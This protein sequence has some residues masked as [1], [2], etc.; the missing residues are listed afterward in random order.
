MKR[1]VL[2]S[3]AAPSELFIGER[4]GLSPSYCS[5]ST[6]EEEQSLV[7]LAAIDVGSN[8]MRL[9]IASVDDDGRMHVVHTDREPVRLG[10]DVFSKGTISDARLVEA[11]DAFLKFRKL[12]NAYKVKSVRAVGTSALREARN[13]NYCIRQIA[14]TTEIT[15][16]VISAEEEARL[17]FLAASGAFKL[18]RKIAL[19]V[20]IGGGSVE[21]SLAAKNEIISTESFGIGTVRLLEMIDQRTQGERVFR[22]LA[23]GYI[24]VSGTR[25][26]KALGEQKIDI[27]IGT[28]GNVESLGDLRVQLCDADDNR[29]I[30]LDELDIILTQLQSRSYEERIKEFGLRRDRADVIIPAII[31]L[32]TVAREARV[33]EI[34]IPRV[35]LREGLLI[36]MARDLGRR[37]PPP[38]RTQLVTSARLLGRKYDYEPEHAQTVSR[39]AVELFDATKRLHRLGSDERVLLEVAGLLHDVGYYLGTTN[40]HK[41]TWYLINA[42][43]LVGCSESEKAIIALVTRYH[44]RSPPKSSHK[45]FVDVPPKRRRLVLM[46][47]SI[48]RLAECLDREH[49]GKVRGFKLTVQRR[50]VTL[51]LK[52]RGDMLLE[53]WALSNGSKLFEK[54][55]K[56]ELV[57][58]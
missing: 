47:A 13:R 43:P 11:M 48:L 24:N 18:Q 6:S 3:D 21:V 28:G 4:A 2:I 16:D 32:Q 5:L 22:Q 54:T 29:S 34:E 50:K 27:F 12:I 14:K 10:G 39:F 49:V 55:F 31:V 35:G 7:R 26:R 15:I 46:L 19:L 8:A 1:E 53:R 25:L 30:K 9:A 37:S 17:A 38:D 51:T 33:G 58:K 36:D 56:R 42:S 45:E 20:D 57:I 52:G 44:T 41:N 40:H 23:R